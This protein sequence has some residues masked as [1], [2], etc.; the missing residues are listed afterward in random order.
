MKEILTLAF[1]AILIQNVLLSR[2]LGTCPFMGVSNKRSSAVGMGLAVVFV[3]TLSSVISW[4][5][6]NYVLVVFEMTYMKTIIFI[7]VIAALVQIIEMFV[8]KV[9][10]PL[11]RS[12]GIYLP[13]ITTNCA[14]LGMAT[15]VGSEEYTLLTAFVFSFASAV[16]F[17]LVMY[18]FAT[19]RER[20]DNGNVPK[21]FRGV[22]IALIS[23]GIMAMIFAKFTGVI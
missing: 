18:I 14:V 22:P 23:A 12:L 4:A 3:I 9:S 2:F 5:L 21:A 7:L 20:I 15:I 13:L 10:P 8:K 1:S 17:L 19:L 6:Y 11:Y 16:G